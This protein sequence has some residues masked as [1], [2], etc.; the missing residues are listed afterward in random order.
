MQGSV[1]RANHSISLELNLVS[2][3]ELKRAKTQLKASMLMALE[4][5]S[6]TVEVL[7]RQMLI[8][9]RV[10]SVKERVEKIE[11]I[12]SDDIRNVANE[13]FASTPSYALMGDIAGHPSYDEIQRLIKV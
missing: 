5:S 11:R 6:S 8:F 9:N 3:K 4:S 7:A 13:I 10:V 12:T 2:E 1:K